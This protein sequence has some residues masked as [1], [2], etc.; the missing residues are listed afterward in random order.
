VKSQEI[1]GQKI[2]LG[3]PKHSFVTKTKQEITENWQKDS[4]KMSKL[5]PKTDLKNTNILFF[6]NEIADCDGNALKIKN[7]RHLQN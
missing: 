6:V 7:I 5:N 4:L 2:C 3:T 1:F